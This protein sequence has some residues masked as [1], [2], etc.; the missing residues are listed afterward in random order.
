MSRL[1]L[2]RKRSRVHSETAFD[3][4]GWCLYPR[5]E[6]YN[7]NRAAIELVTER[8]DHRSSD[9]AHLGAHTRVLP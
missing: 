8:N 4:P 2:A 7:T 6:A 9:L 1:A 5:I 3:T